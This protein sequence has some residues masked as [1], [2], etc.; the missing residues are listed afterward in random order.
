[1]SLSANNNNTSTSIL[2]IK[3]IIAIIIVFSFLLYLLFP[4]NDIDEIIETKGKNTNLSINYIERMILYYPNNIK[5][6]MLLLKKYDSSGKIE[7]ALKLIDKLLKKTKDREILDELYLTQYRL[8]KELYFKQEGN[9]TIELIKDKL[10]NYFK[11]KG[12]DRDYIFFLGEA[13]QMDFKKLKYLS[14]KGLIEQNHK[15]VD[16]NLIKE[17]Y[18]LSL[19]LGYKDEAENYLYRLIEFK[20]ANSTLK[21]TMLSSLLNEKKYKKAIN[22]SIKLFLEERDR[23]RLENYFNIALYATALIDKDSNSSDNIEKLI[24]IYESSRDMRAYDIS[25]ILENL[26]KM[27]YTKEASRFA[28][29]SFKK[30]S[31]EFDE[32]STKLAIDSLVYNQE[33]KSALKIALFAEKKFNKSKWLDESIKLSV[34][35]GKMQDAVLLNEKGLKKYKDKKYEKYLKEKTTIH[36][37]YHI[38]GEIYKKNGNID[39]IIEYY[40]YIGKPQDA[41]VYFENLYKKDKSKKVLKALMEFSYRNRNF[42]KFLNLY[43]IYKKRYGV[44]KSLQQ[45]LINILFAQKRYREAYKVLKELEKLEKHDKRLSKLLAHL[46]IE[47]KFDLYKELIDLGWILHDYKYLYKILWKEDRYNEL[48][49]YNYDK[50]I[51]LEEQLNSGKRLPYLYKKLYKKTKKEIYLK[52]LLSIYS[53]KG[54]YKKFKSLYNSLTPKLKKELKRDINFNLTLTNYYISTSKPKKALNI[55]KRLL[56]K[57]RK[58]AEVHQAYLWFIIDNKLTKLIKKELRVLKRNPK[59]QRE[60]GFPSV[61][62]A[63]ML[64]QTNLALK[65]LRPLLKNSNSLEYQVVYSDILQL[66]DRVEGARR[67]R[68]KLFRRL[69]QIIKKSPKLLKDREFARVYLRLISM[70]GSP[71]EKRRYFKRLK[72][73]FKEKDFMEMKIGWKSYMKSSDMVKYLKEKYNMNLQWLD[74]YLAMSRGDNDK[75]QKLLKKDREI[76]AF[77]DRVIA[78]KD[79]GDMAGAYSLAFKGMEDNS[80]DVDL[81]KIYADMIN[82]DYPKGRAK[83]NYKQISKDI[84]AIET[85][86]EHRW[87]LYRGLEGKLFFNQYRYIQNKNRD[88][89]DNSF[90]LSILNS[91]ERFIWSFELE[92]YFNRG[93]PNITANSKIRY[94]RD[95]SEF[96]IEIKRNSR[97]KRTAKLRM[98]GIQNSIEVGVKE[99]ISNRAVVGVSYRDSRYKIRG[100]KYRGHLKKMRFDTTYTIKRG[101]PDIKI[102]TY[103][104]ISRFRDIKR[105]SKLKKH[106]EFGSQIYIGEGG[107]NS[108]H[109]DLRPYGSFGLSI[110]NKNRIG[111]SLSIGVSGELIGEDILNLSFDYSQGIDLITYPYYGVSL[112]YRF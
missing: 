39:K 52:E 2:S 21:D 69:N 26:L 95:S 30:Y 10:Y 111:S 33:L 79:I 71:R 64:Q 92:K 48:K 27:G 17:A 105:N 94:K 66:Q 99:H 23:K 25:Y 42:N 15:L 106:I 91:S 38:L 96:N 78:S 53:S 57:Y 82:R 5:L 74:L 44:N 50:L 67:V 56:K 98:L 102:N 32:N 90:G 46:K 83:T 108:I 60:V 4:K 31:Q 72:P 59:L 16:F 103:L 109:R 54:E 58:N 63:L 73:L 62:S 88:Y 7:K 34:W 51:L 19:S 35:Q 41:E 40:N 101:Y 65:W 84:L 11:F 89:L 76:L 55:F 1:M 20:D 70:Y 12:G 13:T 104:L 14:L 112:E 6:K 100:E 47:Q 61:V 110:D 24:N 43:K 107:K 45:I 87:H 3:E 77:R 81:Y 68:L 18:Y 29:E 36:N 22:L 85:K 49:Y 37:A 8:L 93:R 28:K 9:V 75:K 86:I 80:R 97:A